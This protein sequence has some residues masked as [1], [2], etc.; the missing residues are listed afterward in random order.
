MF[1]WL[2]KSAK[3]KN[4]PQARKNRRQPSRLPLRLEP[5][6]DRT[7]LSFSTPV[8]VSVNSAGNAAGND[9]A[10]TNDNNPRVLSA[11]GTLEVFSSNATDLVPGGSTD[12]NGN[13]AVF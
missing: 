6:E 5:L 10:A 1:N 2:C 12:S 7:L 3:R 8:L 13:P 4:R 11:D 9:F